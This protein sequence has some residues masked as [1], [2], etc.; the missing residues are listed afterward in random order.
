M[1]K[2]YSLLAL[3]IV[4][5]LVSCKK[6]SLAYRSEF[7][8]S[9]QTWLRFKDSSHNSYQYLTV[10]SSVFGFGS[11]TLVTV[12]AGKVTGRS[13]TSK[14]Y[15]NDGTGNSTVLIQWTEDESSLLT[16]GI[17]SVI[18]TLDDIYEKARVDWLVKRG[19]ATTYF[20]TK[21]RGMISSCGYIPNGCQDDCFHGINIAY[22]KPY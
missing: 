1:K 21:N 11:E 3:L 8:Q 22:I 9:Y 10:T 12:Q 17:D 2:W 14:Q 13:Y 15:A 16:H 4:L 18:L 7:D 6:E 19:D 20:E 5:T